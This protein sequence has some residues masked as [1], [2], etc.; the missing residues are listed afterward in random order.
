MAD[1]LTSLTLGDFFAD[2]R[3]TTLGLC[4]MSTLF[5]ASFFA[6]DIGMSACPC[7]RS[8]GV[9]TGKRRHRLFALSTVHALIVGAFSMYALPDADVARRLPAR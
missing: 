1:A 3:A 8:I 5:C 9:D 4:A 7:L 6:M 2:G